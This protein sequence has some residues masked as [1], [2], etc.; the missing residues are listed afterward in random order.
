MDLTSVLLLLLLVAFSWGALYLLRW[1]G[2]SVMWS[3]I[4]CLP[5]AILG[6]AALILALVVAANLLDRWNARTRSDE[7]WPHPDE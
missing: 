2:L 1:L 3:A 7:L 5:A 4:L 6:V